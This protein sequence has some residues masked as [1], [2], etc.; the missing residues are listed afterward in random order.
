MCVVTSIH[1]TLYSFPTLVFLCECYFTLAEFRDERVCALC[2]GIADSAVLGGERMLHT[3]VAPPLDWVHANCALWSSEVWED[4][5]G[6]LHSLMPG[7][8][9]RASRTKCG[10]CGIKVS[11]LQHENKGWDLRRRKLVL[12]AMVIVNDFQANNSNRG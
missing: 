2:K 1:M 3:G 11:C 10:L 6:F 7:A 8:L 12:R 5:D 9:T 4:R